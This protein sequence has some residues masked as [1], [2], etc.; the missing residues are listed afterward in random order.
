VQTV[1][2]E[3][4]ARRQLRRGNLYLFA[5]MAVFAAGF[6]VAWL[7]P[8]DLLSST[9]S[10]GALLLGIFLWQVSLYFTRRW[11]PRQRQDAALARALKGLDNRYTLVSFADAR[12]P[13]YLLIGPQG[14]RILVARAIDG[15]VRCRRDQ[16]S[17]PGRSPLLSL[18]LGNPIRNPTVEAVQSVS[19]VEQHLERV[20]DAA[21]V[22]SV[23]V[24]ATIVFTHPQVRLEI[25]GSKFPVTTARELRAHILRDKGTLGA[26]QIATLR[27]VLS[28]PPEARPR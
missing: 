20:P 15:T 28:P 7:R 25:E 14:I 6:A 2:N 4:L 27:R 12:L 16:W 26:P 13:D 10:F 1:T 9:V 3:V 11:G 19:Q 23:P 5:A 22:G 21:E 8:E 24:T 18:F 17:R